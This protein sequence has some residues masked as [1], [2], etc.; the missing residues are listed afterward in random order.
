VAVTQEGNITI[1]SWMTE[2]QFLAAISTHPSY[3]NLDQP[4][5]S[6]IF[7]EVRLSTAVRLLSWWR[8]FTHPTRFLVGTDA[9]SRGQAGE[10]REAEA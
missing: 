5:A 1:T 6:K 4:S 10:A 2:G 3:P 8:R 7:A 9:G